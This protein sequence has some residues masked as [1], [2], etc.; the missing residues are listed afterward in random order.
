MVSYAD[1]FKAT[2]EATPVSE[3]EIY[4][5]QFD[6]SDGFIFNTDCNTI[7]GEYAVTCEKI[8]FINPAATEMACDKEIVERSV[9]SQLTSV[10]SYT[11]P[12]DSTL[13][14]AGRQG[15]VLFKFVKAYDRSAE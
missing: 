14:L 15:N 13:Y 10:D 4:T 7:S 9:K 5:L 2:L 1:P 6:D 11:L 12:N 3:D 8:Q